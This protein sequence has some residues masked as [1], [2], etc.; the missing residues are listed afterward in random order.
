M[1]RGL[2]YTKAGVNVEAVKKV[3]KEIE[4]LLK[5]THFTRSGGFGKVSLGAGHYAG[6]IGIGEGKTLACMLMAWEQKL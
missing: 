5:K 1:K 3:H 4:V 6:L 2:T